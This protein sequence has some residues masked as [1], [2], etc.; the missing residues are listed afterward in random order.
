IQSAVERLLKQRTTG[1][2]SLKLLDDVKDAVRTSK[3]QDV[4][5]YAEMLPRLRATFP[6]TP[7]Q[8]AALATARAEA[9]K[10]YLV[11]SAGFA[12]ARLDVGQPAE[13]N[14]DGKAV[15]LKLELGTQTAARGS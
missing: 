12:P 1:G 10:T 14:G 3:P 4:P 9:M 13:A 7:P 11:T 8:L 5:R 2:I 6:V 15:N